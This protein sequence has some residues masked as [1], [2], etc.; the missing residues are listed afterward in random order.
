M[1]L[2]SDLKQIVDKDIA[3]WAARVAK[4]M[5]HSKERAVD[6]ATE[7]QEKRDSGYRVNVTKGGINVSKAEDSETRHLWEGK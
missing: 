5:G 1:S 4:T 2:L 3:A 6:N 7:W